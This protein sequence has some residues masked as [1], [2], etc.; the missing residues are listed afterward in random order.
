MPYQTFFSQYP[1]IS[2]TIGYASPIA[3]FR[4]HSGGRGVRMYQEFRPSARAFA[5][6]VQHG[7][8]TSAAYSRRFAQAQLDALEFLLGVAAENRQ[9][10]PREA[11]MAAAAVLRAKPVQKARL[12]SPLDERAL[13]IKNTRS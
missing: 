6:P 10:N 12:R 3:A 2:R 13:H 9:S 7:S 1:C 8:V 4:G 5:E 11:R